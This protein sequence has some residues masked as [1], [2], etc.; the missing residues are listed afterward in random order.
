MAKKNEKK[1][2]LYRAAGKVGK[3]V[4]KCGDYVLVLLAAAGI[5]LITKDPDIIKKIKK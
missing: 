4:R 2:N 5:S 1:F 3:S